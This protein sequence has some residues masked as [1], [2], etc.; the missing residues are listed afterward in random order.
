[1]RSLQEVEKNI[2]TIRMVWQYVYSRTF[3][4]I[5]HWKNVIF[6]RIDFHFSLYNTISLIVEEYLITSNVFF[7]SFL[8]YNGCGV[9]MLFMLLLFIQYKDNSDISLPLYLSSMQPVNTLWYI[10]LFIVI[11]ETLTLYNLYINYIIELE[12]NNNS[13]T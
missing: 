8:M 6:W 5:K 3:F 11:C 2:I 7:T 4:W 12:K 1:M 9:N 13:T 10:Y